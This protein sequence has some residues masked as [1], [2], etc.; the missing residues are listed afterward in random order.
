MPQKLRRHGKIYKIMK[1]YT[2]TEMLAIWRDALGLNPVNSN[3]NISSVESLDIDHRLCQLM[4][5]LYLNILDTADPRLCPVTDATRQADLSRRGLFGLITLPEGARRALSV[6][7]SEWIN[8]VPVQPYVD[9]MD[10]VRRMASAFAR[11][12]CHEP[13]AYNGAQGVMVAPAQGTVEHF[14]VIADPGEE[15]YILDEVLLSTIPECL[16]HVRDDGNCL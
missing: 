7:M 3:C 13:L 15:L 12:G 1:T 6:K 4:R 14:I 9:V 11:P 16:R 2:K 10:R 8:P 5:Q